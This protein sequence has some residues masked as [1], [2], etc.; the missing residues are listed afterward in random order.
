MKFKSISNSVLLISFIIM[1]SFTDKGMLP[2]VT[3]LTVYVYNLEIK[4]EIFRISFNCSFSR[5]TSS[6][7]DEINIIFFL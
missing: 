7:F 3:F 4:N 2:Q 6:S 5:V 1:S